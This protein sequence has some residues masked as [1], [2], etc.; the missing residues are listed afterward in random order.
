MKENYMDYEDEDFLAKYQN[1]KEEENKVFTPTNNRNFFGLKHEHETSHIQNEK[2]FD[3]EPKN[4][5]I[6]GGGHVGNGLIIRLRKRS[7]YNITIVDDNQKRLEKIKN[8]FKDVRIVKGNATNRKILEKAG[9]QTADIIVVAT[10]TDE[11]NL[12]IGIIAQE[13]GVTKVISRTENPSHIKM[14]KR[15]GLS[16]VVSPELTTCISILKLITSTNNIVELPSTGKESYEIVEIPVTSKKIIGKKIGDISPDKNFII[17]QCFKKSTDQELIA[18]NDIILE[19]GDVITILVKKSHFKK[20][21][22][23]FSKTRR[24]IDSIR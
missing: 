1:F 24:F 5:I 16:E 20:I 17:M 21:K 4:I 2:I 22:K 12:L 14:F 10:S 3:D 13:Y 9:I 15:L 6:V 11:I 8:V 19:E 18:Q 7:N 23:I